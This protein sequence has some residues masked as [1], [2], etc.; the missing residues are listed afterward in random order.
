MP[1]QQIVFWRH[2][3]TDLNLQGRI[4]GSSDIPLNEKGRLQAQTV[5]PELAKLNPDKIYVSDLGRAQETAQ[6]LS[7]LTG[8]RPQ[9]STQL[10]ERCYGVWEGMTSAEIRDKWPQQWQ[11]WRSGNEPQDVGVETREHCGIRVKELVEDAVREA[12]DGETLVFVAHGGSI[13]NGIM[14]LLGMNPSVWAGIQ[15]LDNC[16]WAVLKPREG[17]NPPWRLCSYNL[18][19]MSSDELEN[20]WR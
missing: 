16:R 2:G 13:V 3:Q 5:A 4:Q 8:I 1:V 19:E 6:F 18:S 14:A 15:G 11:Q 17:A 20:V 7:D 12:T 9:V 10:R